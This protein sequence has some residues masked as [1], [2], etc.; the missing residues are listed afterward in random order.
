M[1]NP[2]ESRLVESVQQA[3]AGDG[4]AWTELDARIRTR[5]ST[6]P[7]P[8][9]VD[10]EEVASETVADVWQALRALRDDQKVVNFAMTV[11]RRVAARKCSESKRHAQLP[12]EPV[13]PD[14]PVAERNAESE[15]LLDRLSGTLESADRKL[16]RLLYVVGASP[17]ELADELGVSGGRLRKRTFRLREKLRNSKAWTDG[18]R[19]GGK[20][21]TDIVPSE[22][23]LS[24]SENISENDRPDWDFG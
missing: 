18:A 15:E 17:D 8:R 20:S 5:V 7:L 6:M 10:P 2:S 1:A 14:A 9:H 3:R 4:D 16:F 12:V 21:R 13:A 23:N 22:K 19:A 24:S 11:A